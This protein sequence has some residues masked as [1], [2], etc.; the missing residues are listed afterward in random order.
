MLGPFQFFLLYRAVAVTAAT[1]RRLRR[2]VVRWL[3]LA[4]IPVALLAIAQQLAVPGA[5]S[6]S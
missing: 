3:L 6:W 1:A 2:M 5:A 4:S